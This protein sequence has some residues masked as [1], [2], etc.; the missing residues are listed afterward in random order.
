MFLNVGL[1]MN[2]AERNLRDPPQPISSSRHKKVS[3]F[4]CKEG[5]RIKRKRL[6]DTRHEEINK[7]DNKQKALSSE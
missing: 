5:K 3:F 7:K 2:E 1:L 6:Y 4:I